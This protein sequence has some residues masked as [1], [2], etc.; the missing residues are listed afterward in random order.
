[1]AGGR[2]VGSMRSE[3]GKKLRFFHCLQKPGGSPWTPT[4]GCLEAYVLNFRL[5]G[6]CYATIK[7]REGCTFF[8]GVTQ[9]PS[10]RFSSDSTV[11][12]MWVRW[13]LSSGYLDCLGNRLPGA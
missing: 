3:H 5:L 7:P 6:F 12:S 11:L 4:P 9:Q 2:V 8:P 13:G 10:V 1:M